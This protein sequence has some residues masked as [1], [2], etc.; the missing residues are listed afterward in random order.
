MKYSYNSKELK[1]ILYSKNELF[2]LPYDILI[3][4]NETEKKIKI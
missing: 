1:N 4:N 3:D 2:N